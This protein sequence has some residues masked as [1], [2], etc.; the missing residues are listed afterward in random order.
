MLDKVSVS[1]TSISTAMFSPVPFTASSF[2]SHHI[3]DLPSL[4]VVDWVANPR[5]DRGERVKCRKH[6]LLN[7]TRMY[8]CNI[9]TSRLN[10][11]GTD[12]DPT[13]RRRDDDCLCRRTREIV[14]G[15]EM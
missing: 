13:F 14:C 7:I 3:A 6:I 4:G 15:R 12:I 5:P 11:S 9:T 8:Q 2:L 10:F 1:P